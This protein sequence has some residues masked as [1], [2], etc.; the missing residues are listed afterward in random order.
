MSLASHWCCVRLKILEQAQRFSAGCIIPLWVLHQPQGDKQEKHI[1]SVYKVD[2]ETILLFWRIVFYVY[3][4]E[5]DVSPLKEGG[6]R[7]S[8]WALRACSYMSKAEGC[9]Q[10]LCPPFSSRG[11]YGFC[12]FLPAQ[13]FCLFSRCRYL[14]MN[15]EKRL[16]RVFAHK[17]LTTCNATLKSRNR[18]FDAYFVWICPYFGMDFSLFLSFFDCFFRF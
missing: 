3:R 17:V 15:R 9:H 5:E 1:S 16:F 14:V 10:G 18:L 7:L 8:V 12:L 2:T 6:G 4:L 11:F 13:D